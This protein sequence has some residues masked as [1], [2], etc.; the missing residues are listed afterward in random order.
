MCIRDRIGLVSQTIGRWHQQKSLESIEVKTKSLH[1]T[2]GLVHAL[3]RTESVSDA[4]M[5][6]VNN[7]RRLCNTDQV[8]LALVEGAK[9]V[10]LKAISDVEKVDLNSESSKII[11]N[12]LSQSVVANQIVRFPIQKDEHSPAALALDKYCKSN[13]IEGCIGLPLTTEDELSLIHI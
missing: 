4:S 1:D 10:L 12:A 2:I 9:D 8:S 7:L 3:D 11:L 5:V 6:V 13:S